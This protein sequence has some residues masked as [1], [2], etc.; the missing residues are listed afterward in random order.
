[1]P[2]SSTSATSSAKITLSAPRGSESFNGSS[3]AT[4]TPGRPLRTGQW[5]LADHTAHY[6]GHGRILSGHCVMT[7]GQ[8]VYLGSAVY[9]LLHGLVSYVFDK[10][11][12]S[13]ITVYKINSL[14]YAYSLTCR[15][16]TRLKKG[17]LFLP[18]V[19]CVWYTQRLSWDWDWRMNGQY[20]CTVLAQSPFV[21][22]SSFYVKYLRVECNC[23][24]I[25]WYVK[26]AWLIATH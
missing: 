8:E 16:A 3:Y 1:M 5:Y 10:F 23:C 7:N 22:K 11:V 2:I 17:S 4:D 9:H 15:E 19:M 14:L 26:P 21:P 20:L 18:V 13:L 24:F 6:T 25:V 12:L